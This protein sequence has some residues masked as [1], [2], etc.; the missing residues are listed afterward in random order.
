[1]RPN[2][3]ESGEDHHAIT[4]K[5]VAAVFAA[6]LA[7]SFLLRIFYAGHLYQDDGLWFTAAEEVLR[8]KAL[9]SEIYFDKPPALPL[10]YALL[11][12]LFGVKI[13]TIRLFTIVYAVAVSWVLYLFG[14]R[15]Y[16][17]KTGLLAAAVFTVFSTTYTTGHFQG[18]NTDFLMVLPYAASAYLLA[19]SHIARNATLAFSGGVLTGLAAGIN[20]KAVFN[21]LFFA[22]LLIVMSPTGST[23]WGLNR[24]TFK[25]SFTLFAIAVAGFVVGTLPFL[26]YVAATGSLAAYWLY[27][28][29]WGS[30][31]TAYYSATRAVETALSQ[32]INYF[33]LN[34]TLLISLI[35]V[36]ASAFRSRRE[37]GKP[38]TELRMKADLALLI[39]L[40]VSYA[41]VATGGRF[42]GHYFFQILPALS[43]LGARGLLA[44]ASA[45]KAARPTSRLWKIRKPVVALVCLG[46]IITIARFHGRTVVLAADWISGRKSDSTAEW[47]HD[48]LNSE[49][50]R[51]AAAVKEGSNASDH[52]F[53]WGYR[54]EI[55]YWSGLAPASRYLSTQPLTGVPAD[56]HYFGDDHRYLLDEATTASARAE[57]LADLNRTRPRYI[58]D[59]LGFFNASLAI[60]SY[61]ELE[62]FLNEYERPE[63]T[64]RFFI[65][66]RKD[67]ERE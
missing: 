32:T 40:A 36:I 13:I 6:L 25:P 37:T 59:E 20:P 17:K 64:G 60:K 45:L 34:N 54:P 28:W 56:V 7:I 35:V 67:G 61:P 2:L 27:V 19:R 22:V 11:F 23:G 57:L 5:T 15:L 24:E 50:R 44:I 49:E 29:D 9:Y 53:V 39:W 63:L 43:L 21:L 55:Y 38:E 10:L 47:F 58:I 12:K 4:R 1:M 62:L 31:Y 8:G 3:R 30:R 52:L 46:F 42:F 14:S 66:R 26:L 51:A 41:G 33:V 65:Y 48:R 16:D 18:L